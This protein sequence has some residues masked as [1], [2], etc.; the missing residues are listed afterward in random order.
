MVSS[1]S[2]TSRHAILSCEGVTRAYT[3][4]G[5]GWR[6]STSSQTVVAVDDVS[7]SISTGDVV[8]LAGPSGSGKSTL[9][10]LLAGLDTPTKGRVVLN[11]T[12]TSG[13]SESARAKLRLDEV[14]IVFQHFHLLPSLSARANA[15]LPLVQRGVSK[16]TRRNK[17]TELLNAVGLA[18]RATHKPSE[19]S[20]GEQ[21][22]V[23]IARALVTD[24]SLLIADEPTGELD[25]N[26]GRQILNLLTD[27]A[28]DRAVVI[29]SHDDAVLE[30]ADRVLRL[31]DGRLQDE[32]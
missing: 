25:S 20:G 16:S 21:Q 6:R 10:H 32:S 18:D 28:D 15:A 27:V 5:S 31:H 9:L 12:D 1:D 19:L 23:A 7:T 22:R 2:N 3:R 11:G 24:P 26:T 4:G 14:G 13:L 29:A 8:G 30:R 17:A